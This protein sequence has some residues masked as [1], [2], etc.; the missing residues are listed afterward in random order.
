[1]S[2]DA[3][4]DEDQDSD[5]RHPE[6]G[7]LTDMLGELRVLLPPAQL[8]SG[9]LIAVPFAPGFSNIVQ[10]EKTV[11][12]ATFMLA[13][14]S[15][16]LLTAPAV[17]HRLMRPLKNRVK[18]KHRASMFMLVGACSLGIALVLATQL[19]LSQ[20]LGAQVA[21]IAAGVVAVLILLFW[22][23]IPLLWKPRQ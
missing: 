20:V 15:L 23:V 12:L 5:E 14:I 6:D 7:D 17:Q 2:N 1:M 10:A 16:V 3:F 8:L 4:N 9:F 13:L 19:V 22:L 21:N 18:F 11:F